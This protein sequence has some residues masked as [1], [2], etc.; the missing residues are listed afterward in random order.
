MELAVATKQIRI[1]E[2]EMDLKKNKNRTG[3]VNFT[4]DRC[5]KVFSIR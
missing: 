2:M 4:I 5:Q 3:R 1:M